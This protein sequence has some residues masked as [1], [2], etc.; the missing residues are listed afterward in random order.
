MFL[1]KGGGRGGGGDNR[2][3]VVAGAV[4]GEASEGALTKVL[5]QVIAKKAGIQ[6]GGSGI[7]VQKPRLANIGNAVAGNA[8]AATGIE[9]KWMLDCGC[10]IYS[11]NM[12]KGII[13]SG[14]RKS[15]TST[16]VRGHTGVTEVQKRTTV[17]I[18]E[19]GGVFT[20][21]SIV[22]KGGPNMSPLGRLVH[23]DGYKVR[24]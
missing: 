1:G 9:G 24:E 13:H 19:L 17:A 23:G 11:T 4:V 10:N 21:S 8:V 15:E 16:S 2:K 22:S 14:E 6:L 12:G 3:P 20:R 5:A 18:P 7:E